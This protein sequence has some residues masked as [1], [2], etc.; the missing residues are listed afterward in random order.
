ML[1]IPI[2]EG[3]DSDSGVR[4]ITWAVFAPHIRVS[5][6][7]SKTGPMLSRR[8]RQTS[9]S[10]LQCFLRVRPRSPRLSTLLGHMYITTTVISH[11]HGEHSVCC[12]QCGRG[13]E[14][15]SAAGERLAFCGVLLEFRFGGFAPRTLEFTVSRVVVPTFRL[16]RALHSTLA[17]ASTRDSASCSV[18]IRESEDAIVP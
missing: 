12:L 9:R 15:F 10:S 14:R 8:S 2:F 4:K 1:D 7:Q 16:S 17:F 5:S 18:A 3:S 6:C 13:A 11:C